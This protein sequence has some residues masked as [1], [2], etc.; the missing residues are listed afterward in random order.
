[1]KSDLWLSKYKKN[2]NNISESPLTGKVWMDFCYF[3]PSNFS[4]ILSLVKR[5]NMWFLILWFSNFWFPWI[6]L[7]KFSIKPKDN[8][9]A[10]FH[11]KKVFLLFGHKHFWSFSDVRK[12]PENF[13]LYHSLKLRNFLLIKT[14]KYIF[15][16]GMGKSIK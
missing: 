9:T 15:I 16:S 1:M 11:E 7:M 4:P 8:T 2:G 14:V 3:W 6:T 5:L 13:S 10:K 12:T